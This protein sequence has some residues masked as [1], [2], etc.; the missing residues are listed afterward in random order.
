MNSYAK[1]AEAPLVGDGGV[2]APAGGEDDPFQ[3]LD[4][5]MAVVEVLCPVWP[6]R[7]SF[8]DGGKML[9]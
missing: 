3:R 9:L 6:Q 2:D 1:S 4:E 8:I 5:L 7:E